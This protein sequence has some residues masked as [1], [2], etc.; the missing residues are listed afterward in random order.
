MGGA[1][2][3]KPI[4]GAVAGHEGPQVLALLFSYVDIGIAF[5][6]DFRSIS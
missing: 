4:N 2:G 6:Y 5:F 3:G 1:I